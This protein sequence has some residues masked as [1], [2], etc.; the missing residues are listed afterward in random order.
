[1]HTPLR[2][3]DDLPIAGRRTPAKGVFPTPDGETLLFCTVCADDRSTHWCTNREVLDALTA[4]WSRPI[5][6]WLVGDFLLMPDHLHFFCAPASGVWTEP[7]AWT[8]YWK[9]EWHKEMR[10][11][12]P[13]ATP[14][15]WQRG[16]FHHRLRSEREFEDKSTYMLQNPVHAGLVK[17][18]AEWPW[19]GRIH[20]L[21]WQGRAVSPP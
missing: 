5:M 16:L 19:H 3:S 12:S 18:P 13:N 17:N 2:P 10:S 4:V 7:E 21:C 15:K 14:P 20:P 1:M 6:H 11:L 9:S 8:S